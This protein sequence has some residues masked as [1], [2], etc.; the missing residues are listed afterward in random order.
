[1]ILE[2]GIREV[3]GLPEDEPVFTQ[4]DEIEGIDAAKER[5]L[6]VLPVGATTRLVRETLE[7]FTGA[8]VATTP[9]ALRGFELALQK[10]FHLFIFGMQ[11]GELSGPMLYELISKAY[12]TGHGPRRLAPGVVFIRE[13]EDPKLPEELKRDARVKDVVSKPIRIDRLL[14]AVKGSLKVLDPTAR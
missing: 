13:K 8:E 5:V 6:V 7:N 3:E 1:M 11:V 14:S 9:D 2:A 12:T 4:V 10:S